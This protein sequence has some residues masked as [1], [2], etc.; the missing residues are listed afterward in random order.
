MKIVLQLSRLANLFGMLWAIIM[1]VYYL[2]TSALIANLYN[3]YCDDGDCDA[4]ESKFTVFP[5]LG[6]IIMITWVSSY[7]LACCQSI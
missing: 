7:V 6:F 1:A 5:V 3:R 2:I 4:D